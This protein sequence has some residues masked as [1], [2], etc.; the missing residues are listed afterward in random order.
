MARVSAAT[1]RRFASV[2]CI[3]TCGTFAERCVGSI[4]GTV[5]GELRDPERRASADDVEPGIMTHT[6]AEGMSCKHIRNG[7]HGVC[8]FMQHT[9][10]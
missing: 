1:V 8:V 5:E 7:S 2:S 4:Y 10:R 6:C 3:A 9:R